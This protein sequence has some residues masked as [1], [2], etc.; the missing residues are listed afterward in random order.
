[1]TVPYGHLMEPR[2]SSSSAPSSSTATS[3]TTWNYYKNRYRDEHHLARYDEDTIDR[4]TLPHDRNN[5]KAPVLQDDPTFVQRST[6]YTRIFDAAMEF[7][8]YSAAD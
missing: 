6:G 8:R 5:P 3:T 4:R 7:S 2:P 1:M